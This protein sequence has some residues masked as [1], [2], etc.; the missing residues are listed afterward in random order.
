MKLS[1]FS[2]LFSLS[3]TL[4]TQASESTHSTT[5]GTNN[6][7]Y[8]QSP[9]R[10][11]K[12]QRPSIPKLTQPAP[13]SSV[14]AG[15]IELKWTKIENATA[16]ALQVSDDPIFY[17]LLVNEPLYRNTSYTLSNM[18]WEAGK[19]YYWRVAA[20]KEDNHPGTIKSLFN[21]SSFTIK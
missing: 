2:F 6:D 7:L 5:H 8:Q 17:N 11:E 16:Y 9:P 3:L 15:P 19:N 18:K 21:R 13:L 14:A 12:V 10:A 20:V 1:L 4:V